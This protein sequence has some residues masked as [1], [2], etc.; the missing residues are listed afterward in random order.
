MAVGC[1][2]CVGKL[3]SFLLLR[4][5]VRIDTGCFKVL[6]AGVVTS[7]LQSVFGNTQAAFGK[8]GRAVKNRWIYLV[9]M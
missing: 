4:N 5:V 8:P 1:G 3:Y 2:N 9:E 6:E 7:L